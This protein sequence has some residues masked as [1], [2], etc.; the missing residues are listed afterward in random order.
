M[1]KETASSHDPSPS[2]LIFKALESLRA[3]DRELAC[4]YYGINQKRQPA[5]EIGQVLDLS[6]RQV[7]ERI[8]VA[9]RGLRHPAQFSYVKAALFNGNDALWAA[10]ADED[11]IVYKKDYPAEVCE[12]I[13]GE[14]LLAIECQFESVADWLSL[15]AR[16]NGRCWY[17]TQFESEDVEQITRRLHACSA[18]L[19][20]KPLDDVARQLQAPIP[21]LRLICQIDLDFQ[22]YWGYVLKRPIRSKKVRAVRMHSLL[23]RQR[24]TNPVALPHLVKEYHDFFNDDDCT[25]NDLISAMVLQPHLFMKLGRDRWAAVRPL[26][27]SNQPDG[28]AAKGFVGLSKTVKSADLFFKWNEERRARSDRNLRKEISDIVESSGP[29]STEEIFQKL[30]RRKP[31]LFAKSSVQVFLCLYDQFIEMA[32]GIY[33]L[34]KHLEGQTP[35]PKLLKQMLTRHACLHYIYARHAGEPM[36]LYPLWT[37]AMEEACCKWAEEKLPKQ[38]YH[39]LLSVVQPEIWPAS[40]AE[41]HLWIWKKECLGVYSLSTVLRR[42]LHQRIPELRNLHR[43]IRAA[44]SSGTMNWIQGNHI[45]G[46]RFAN[47]NIVSILALMI[48]LKALTPE[49]AWHLP[50]RATTQIVEVDALLCES[51]YQTGRLEWR[52]E[53]GREVLERCSRSLDQAAHG[54]IQPQDWEKLLVRLWNQTK[55]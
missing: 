29:S 18:L 17:R 13:P 15:N 41:K 3:A 1:L 36:T 49:G 47:Q 21:L 11:G 51:L 50:H 32:P 12:R 22:F 46:E 24:G 34:A 10:A 35:L 27:F 30:Q 44:H 48:G 14:L 28:A 31:P 52:Q 4:A 55:E 8:K 2:Q 39:S 25:S 54:W 26:Q 53:A 38:L 20:P 6:A 40:D 37:P 16:E 23:S 5:K 45:I 43:V 9:L 19:L 7:T 42:P 33:G